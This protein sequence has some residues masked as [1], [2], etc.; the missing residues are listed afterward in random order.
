MRVTSSPPFSSIPRTI[1]LLPSCGPRPPPYG[2]A[3][4][5]RF[6]D[7]NDFA[8]AAQRI[9]TVERGH[10]LADFMAHAPRGFVGHANLALDTLGG[11]AVPRRREQE[12]DVEPIAQAGAGAIERRSG[13]RVKLIGAPW[14]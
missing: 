14:H 6:V 8:G 13:S 10:V 5:Q 7:L 9:V 3:A 11:N 12:H 4:D 1:V 2:L